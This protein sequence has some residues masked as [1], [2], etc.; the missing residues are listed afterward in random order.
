[1]VLLACPL[2]QAISQIYLCVDH[3][4]DQE[5]KKKDLSGCIVRRHNW[6]ICRRR[7]PAAVQQIQ[8]KQN[9]IHNVE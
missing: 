1:M 2:N 4:E 7:P 5:R 6:D 3:F 8:T 9:K